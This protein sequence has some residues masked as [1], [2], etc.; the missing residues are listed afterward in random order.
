M[1]DL[2]RL[3]GIVSLIN[4]ITIIA[5]VCFRKRNP[6]SSMAWIMFLIISPVI[7]GIAFLIF[8]VGISSYSRYRYKK[9]LEMNENA[10]LDQQRELAK[11]QESQ[12]LRYAE[13]VKY[14]LN[15]GCVYCEHN[16]VKIFTDAE[17]KYEALLA[18]IENAAESINML[19]FII[20]NDT[21]GNRIIDALCKKAEEGVKVRLMYDGLGSLLT[22]RRLFNRLR[23]V[24]GCEVAEFFPVRILSMSKINHRNHRKIVVIDDKIAY[25]GGMN[26]GDE[27]MSRNKKRKLIWRDTHMRIVGGA[28]EYVQ[29]CFAQDWEFSTGKEIPVRVFSDNCA[30]DVPMQIVAS[31]P[32]TMNEEIKSGMIRMVYDAKS[33][34]KIH[35]PYFVP[36][37]AFLS[38]V[39]TASQS[40]VD[41][42]VMIP[43][44]P[45]KKYV[46]HTTMSYV[47]EL[48]DAG[49]RVFLYPG[50]I[51]SKTMTV[52]DEIATIGSA[53]VDI[54]SFS[55]LFEINAFMYSPNLAKECRSIFEADEE[56]CH[57]LTLEEYRKRGFIKIVKEGFFR[58]FSPIL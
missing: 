23:R 5:I 33:H 22:P 29:R 48:L 21:I 49:V 25:M 42:R 4:A 10:V 24:S 46:Y 3:S 39:K 27:Y 34:I 6:L 50:F 13:M 52:D 55:L 32:D 38:A 44:V 26:I 45:D 11:H 53:N 9:K 8:G 17:E 7:G 47:G 54:R 37:D 41:V 19:Y 15:S 36:D 51:H 20:R 12:N 31:G 30:G 35:T 2:S 43:G 57:E 28:V 16:D 58:L 56:K 14:F 18:D 1:I 40:G